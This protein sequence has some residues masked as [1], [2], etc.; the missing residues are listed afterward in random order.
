MN[1]QEGSTVGGIAGSSYGTISDCSYQGSIQNETNSPGYSAGGI[2]GAVEDNSKQVLACEADGS[3]TG[4]SGQELGGIVGSWTGDGEVSSC[5]NRMNI[6]GGSASAGIV[7]GQT[8]EGSLT[9]RQCRS[10]ISMRSSGRFIPGRP[11]F[12]LFTWLRAHGRSVPS[13]ARALRSMGL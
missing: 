13:S 5:V 7:G 10:L 1:A 8:T 6:T 3:L 2:V 4:F 12:R 11:R 9:I